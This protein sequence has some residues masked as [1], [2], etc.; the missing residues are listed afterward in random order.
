MEVHGDEVIMVRYGRETNGKPKNTLYTIRKGESIYF[1]ISRCNHKF[2][3]FRKDAGKHIAAER[4]VLAAEEHE[5]LPV[6]DFEPHER[7]LR[8]VCTR[9]AIVELLQYFDHIDD[10]LIDKLNGEDT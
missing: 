6:S 2:D 4:A 10:I 7:G 3:Q 5:G 1:G 9:S 8:G